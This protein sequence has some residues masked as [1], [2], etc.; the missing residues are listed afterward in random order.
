VCWATCRSA[1]WKL[2]QLLNS[3]NSLDALLVTSTA[4]APSRTDPHGGMSDGILP[5]STVV[6]RRATAATTLTPQLL[7]GTDPLCV[8]VFGNV[9]SGFGCATRPGFGCVMMQARVILGRYYPRISPAMPMRIVSSWYDIF[10]HM[11]YQCRM[12]SQ[13]PRHQFILSQMTYSPNKM[14]LKSV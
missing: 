6:S 9:Q 8:A 12:L 13:T 5:V 14:F 1:S 7:N 10:P 2:S 3:A 4:G 11:S